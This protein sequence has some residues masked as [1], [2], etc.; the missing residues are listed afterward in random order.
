MSVC[1]GG[2]SSSFCDSN[3]ALTARVVSPRPTPPPLYTYCF[4]PRTR[5]RMASDSSALQRL[6]E[7]T[8]QVADV[9][10][11]DVQRESV[12]KWVGEL[13][14]LVV[15]F[16]SFTPSFSRFDPSSR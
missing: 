11:S 5:A 1:L 16:L 8:L 3:S 14:D 9:L 4:S 10:V 12:R 15:R 6:V 13:R 7:E 2:V